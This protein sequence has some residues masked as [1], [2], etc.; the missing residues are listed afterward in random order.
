VLIA[1]SFVFLFVGIPNRVLADADQTEAAG[2]LVHSCANLTECVDGEA[3][4]YSSCCS[5]QHCT[6]CHAVVLRISLIAGRNVETIA[7]YQPLR[8]L[9]VD[10][11]PQFKPPRIA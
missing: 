10:N 4:D 1:A 6:N 2:W 7:S 11:Q 9:Q 3:L 8:H 5:G